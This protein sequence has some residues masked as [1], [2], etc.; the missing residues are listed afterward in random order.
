[1]W[2]YRI[3]TTQSK[4]LKLAAARSPSPGTSAPAPTALRQTSSVRHNDLFTHSEA[5]RPSGLS[6]RLAAA[7]RAALQEAAIA[8]CPA[9]ALQHPLSRTRAVMV[10]CGWLAGE[11]LAVLPSSCAASHSGRGAGQHVAPCMC[12]ASHQHCRSSNCAASGC[13]SGCA[14][15]GTPVTEAARRVRRHRGR[16]MWCPHC[17]RGHRRCERRTNAVDAASQ[18]AWGRRVR[19]LPLGRR[20]RERFQPQGW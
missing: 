19:C 14:H 12:A 3:N 15:T 17:T 5:L 20:A 16:C 18:M 10:P 1:M 6:P 2:Q 8:R 9:C 11:P 7:C 13:P 4:R